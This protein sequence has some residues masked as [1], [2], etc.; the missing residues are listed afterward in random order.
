M[1]KRRLSSDI[2]VVPY[3]DVMLV[4]LIIFMVTAPLMTQGI[5]VELPK[6]NAQSMTVQ[7]EDLILSVGPTGEI[8]LSIGDAQDQPK[9]DD[10]VL[11]I[12]GKI[13]RANP[14]RMILIH[15]DAAVPYDR[16]AHA[17]WLLQEVGAKKVGFVTQPREDASAK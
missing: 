14:E 16:V 9:S 15:G 12:I 1:A 6:A 10:E 2:N 4:L 11:D 7:E 17:M 3:I 5:E 13:I 8:F